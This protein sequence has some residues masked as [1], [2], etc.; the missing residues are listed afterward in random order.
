MMSR[1][2]H[3]I[4][5]LGGTGKAGKYLVEELLHRNLSVR[6]LVRNPSR[7]HLKDPL[8]EITEGNARSYNSLRT[9]LTGCDCVLST[10]GPSAN[11]HDT[12]SM[13]TGHIVKIMNEMHIS[14]YIVVAGL[15]IQAQTDR[16][17]LRTRLIV[18]ILKLFAGKVIADRQ[19]EFTLLG[20]SRLDWTVVRCPLIRQT[21]ETGQVKTST[22][23]SPGNKVS[24]AD[25]AR[26]IVDE[27][28]DQN[29][30]QKAP[31]ISN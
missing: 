1:P 9:L 8:L 22:E 14:R 10:L 6:M 16:K 2:L 29:Y 13:A 17:R 12:C 23:D 27:A 3:K 26:F 4:A 21:S 31:F 19:K 18:A 24:A 25:L 7:V 15:G 20:N 11:E 30:L 28:Q 5:V